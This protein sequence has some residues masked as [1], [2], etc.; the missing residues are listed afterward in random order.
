MNSSEMLNKV[1]AEL[2]KHNLE[3]MPLE[4]AVTVALHVLQTVAEQD[5]P[6]FPKSPL[7]RMLASLLANVAILQDTAMM[8][9]ATEQA[10]GILSL[11]LTPPVGKES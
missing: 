11:V 1:M 8:V 2:N 9:Y 6:E 4:E 5:G 10:T 7:A 3:P